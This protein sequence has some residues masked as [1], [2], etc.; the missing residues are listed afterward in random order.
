MIREGLLLNDQ[1]DSN[2]DRLCG[3]TPVI[4]NTITEF[5]ILLLIFLEFKVTDPY[6]VFFNNVNITIFVNNILLKFILY[7]GHI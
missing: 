5:Y 4:I 2:T 3:I 1:K 6:K 7:I